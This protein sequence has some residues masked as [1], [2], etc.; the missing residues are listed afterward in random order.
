[1]LKLKKVQSSYLYGLL[2]TDELRMMYTTEIAT[3][4]KKEMLFHSSQAIVDSNKNREKLNGFTLP[5]ER[6]PLKYLAFSVEDM[7]L[8]AFLMALD[9]VDGNCNLKEMA[10]TET[11]G[12][13]CLQSPDSAASIRF[14]VSKRHKKLSK[15]PEFFVRT[16]YNG[17]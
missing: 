7:G 2:S 5:P 15:Y 12:E 1:M 8:S 14:E 3:V 17:K 9:L 4:I 11:K 6:V 10:N 13:P 16:F